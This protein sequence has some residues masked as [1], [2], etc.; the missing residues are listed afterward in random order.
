ME[1][2]D[3]VNLRDLL[4]EGRL[5]AKQ[6]L[7]IVPPICDALQYAHEKGIVHRDI[8]PENLLL[9]RD[10]RVKIA[11]FG[12]AALVGAE[13]E[14]AGTPP[15]MA[16]EQ[17]ARRE[18][19]HRADIYALGVVLYEMLTGERPDSEAIAPSR[20][21]QIDVR[22]DE[23]VLRALEKNPER[24]YA[25]ASVFKTQVE[26]LSASP[27]AVT[28]SPVRTSSGKFRREQMVI[29][30]AAIICVIGF[31]LGLAFALDYPRQSAGPWILVGST[32]L[33]FIVCGVRLAGLWPFPSLLFPRPNFSS[34]N[35]GRSSD[36]RQNARPMNANLEGEEDISRVVISH[37]TAILCLSALLVGLFVNSP[38]SDVV[39]VIG[40]TGFIAALADFE[41]ARGL[42]IFFQ[43]GTEIGS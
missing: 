35:L 7:A 2:V 42:A 26:T 1:F 11:D 21:V 10:G 24:R 3:G 23:I 27:D 33:G 29:C 17:T 25:Q 28:S 20:K 37:I 8:K 13:G 18:V 15:Y 41:A 43:S 32:I 22:L 31:I 12:I 4:R 9:D 36:G 16:P 39:I 38:H 34:R 14:P 19:D 30:G 40:I 6:A 5:E